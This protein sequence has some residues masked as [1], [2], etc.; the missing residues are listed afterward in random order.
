MNF[1]AE[2]KPK[3][4]DSLSALAD[5]YN[6]FLCRTKAERLLLIFLRKSILFVDFL[7]EFL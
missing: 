4:S 7:W 6:E 5:T 3:G 1:F 2:Q